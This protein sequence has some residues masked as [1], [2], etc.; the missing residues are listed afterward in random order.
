MKSIRGKKGLELE[1]RDLLSY[2]HTCLRPLAKM[3]LRLAPLW[4]NG[5]SLEII[6]LRLP[7]FYVYPLP[8][9]AIAIFFVL[10]GNPSAS[11]RI[12]LSL[13]LEHSRVLSTDWN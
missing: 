12:A 2:F 1:L 10:L 11:N 13:S 7:E 3:F 6:Q 5:L 8:K 4:R 9:R